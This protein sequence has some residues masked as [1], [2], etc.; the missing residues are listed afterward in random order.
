[1]PQG[2]I[3]PSRTLLPTIRNFSFSRPRRSR[4]L[5]ESIRLRQETDGG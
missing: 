2:G 3:R 5:H 1:M 4:A